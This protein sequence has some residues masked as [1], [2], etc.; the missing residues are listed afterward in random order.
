VAEGPPQLDPEEREPPNPLR[1]L[2]CTLTFVI[3]LGLTGAFVYALIRRAHAGAKATQCAN[4]LRQVSLAA[5]EYSSDKRFLPHVGRIREYDGDAS[6]DHASR[7]MA[8]LFY[9]GYSERPEIL[10]CPIAGSEQAYLGRF[11]RD[12]RDWTWSGQP[13][14]TPELSPI[15][16]PDLGPTLEDSIEL[17]FSWSRRGLNTGMSSITILAGDKGASDHGLGPGRNL[18]QGDAT[19]RYV[20]EDDPERAKLEVLDRRGACL[21]FVD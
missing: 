2:G 20:K 11:P 13:N 15:V 8:A 6:T 5:I 14:P 1:V 16:A 10:I 4:N 9:Y 19:V 17:S 18:S 12:S 7:A 3:A 21:S